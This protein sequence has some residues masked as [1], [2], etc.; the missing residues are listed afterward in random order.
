VRPAKAHPH[1][2]RRRT[3][4]TAARAAATARNGRTAAANEERGLCL[5]SQGSSKRGSP[6]AKLAGSANGSFYTYF[7]SKEDILEAV[8]MDVFDELEA[9]FHRARYT[10]S[11]KPSRMPK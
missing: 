10:T 6:I 5:R 2:T 9:A 8:A 7:D 11:P 4:R 3:P 1:E